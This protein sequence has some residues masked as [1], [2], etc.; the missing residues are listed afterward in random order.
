MIGLFC[1]KLIIYFILK[2]YY[3]FGINKA[4]RFLEEKNNYKSEDIL[5]EVKIKFAS[6]VTEYG[7]LGFEYCSSLLYMNLRMVGSP[8]NLKCLS[9][10]QSGY[11]Q[12]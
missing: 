10:G 5:A 2:E 4:F 3:N 1:F 7:P 6:Y 11:T 9:V 12:M 8:G